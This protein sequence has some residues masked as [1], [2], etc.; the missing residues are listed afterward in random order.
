M[1]SP[2]G[3]RLPLSCSAVHHFVAKDFN[4]LA[5]VPAGSRVAVAL[6]NG[7]DC[8]LA[9][10]ACIASSACVPLNPDGSQQETQAVLERLGCVALLCQ[11]AGAPS[12]AAKACGV[13]RLCLEAPRPGKHMG[14]PRLYSPDRLRH[15]L[16]PGSGDQSACVKNTKQAEQ[17]RSFTGRKDTA[18]MIM[19][20][21]TTGKVKAEIGRASC[22]ERV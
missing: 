6:P 15:T 9:T 22:R 19:T 11:E 8:A 20:S 17:P 2:E 18:L 16:D 13:M 1:L 7:L 5:W 3:G 21:C 12:A 10:L 14:F 4:L